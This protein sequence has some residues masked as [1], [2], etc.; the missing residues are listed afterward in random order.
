MHYVLKG[1]QGYVH[2]RFTFCSLHH[3]LDVQCDNGPRI[4]LTKKVTAIAE[5]HI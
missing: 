4:L 5:G 2:H 3:L 1:E